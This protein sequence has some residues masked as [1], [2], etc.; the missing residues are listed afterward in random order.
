MAAEK[1]AHVLE[2]YRAAYTFRCVPYQLCYA[3]YVAST[4]LVRNANS[5][6]TPGGHVPSLQHLAICLQ[7]FH[8]MKLTHPGAKRMEE[9][10]MALMG[11]L[12]VSMTDQAIYHNASASCKPLKFSMAF[13]KLLTHVSVP[14][15]RHLTAPTSVTLL[16]TQYNQDDALP[17]YEVTA[18][19]SQQLRHSLHA[20][21]EIENPQSSILTTF[22]YTEHNLPTYTLHGNVPS[23]VQSMDAA[24]GGESMWAFSMD[25]NDDVLFGVLRDNWT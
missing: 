5:P 25:I 7:G 10:I 18:T 11:R 9:R 23:T 24:F 22:E 8:E 1:I 6:G 17:A 3:T 15:Q 2:A 13:R 19:Q 14:Y 20:Y 16:G 12:D 21:G 4:V